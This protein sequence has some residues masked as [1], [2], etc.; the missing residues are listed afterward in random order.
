MSPGSLFICDCCYSIV[1][2]PDKSVKEK[3]DFLVLECDHTI[4]ILCNNVVD[5]QLDQMPIR[6]N[7]AT[8]S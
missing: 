6:I 2:T 1:E 4:I 3:S 8:F 7:S 5:H